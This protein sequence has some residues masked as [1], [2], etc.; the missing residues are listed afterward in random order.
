[1]YTGHWYR[2]D[3][4]RDGG[5]VAKT[6]EM[7]RHEEP[8]T[9]GEFTTNGPFFLTL[10]PGKDAETDFRMSDY[11]DMTEPGAYEITLTEE[12]DPF[13]THKIMVVQSNT[14]KITVVPAEAQ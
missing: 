13:H 10:R 4:S 7:L 8:P 6:R 14:I 1:M 9:D 5:P 2:V 3:I 11:Y 12:A